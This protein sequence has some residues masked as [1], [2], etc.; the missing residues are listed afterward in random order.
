MVGLLEKLP[1]EGGNCQLFF[2]AVKPLIL[3]IICHPLERLNIHARPVH[4]PV[5]Q[6][7][8]PV[9]RLFHTARA[10]VP[11]GVF[12]GANFIQENLFHFISQEGGKES[13]PG[14]NL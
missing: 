1:G 12:D 6:L 8:R 5:K 7:E 14:T 9:V 4:Q 2:L 11:E 13:G 3:T 10:G